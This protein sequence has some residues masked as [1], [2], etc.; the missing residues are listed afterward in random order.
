MSI[1]DKGIFGK[2]ILVPMNKARPM[3]ADGTYETVGLIKKNLHSSDGNTDGATTK[4]TSAPPPHTDEISLSD[5]G[6]WAE[7]KES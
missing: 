5:G 4:L 6:L 2:E 1:T 3:N 7:G